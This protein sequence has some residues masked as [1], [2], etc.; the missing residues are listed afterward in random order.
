MMVRIRVL[1]VASAEMLMYNG[2]QL[3]ECLFVEIMG[4]KD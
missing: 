4:K 1:D 3:G 2:G